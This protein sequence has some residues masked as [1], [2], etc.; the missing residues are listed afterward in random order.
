MISPLL[1]AQTEGVV[2]EEM[3]GVLGW[4]GTVKVA[5]WVQGPPALTVTVYEPGVRLEIVV[6]VPL[7]DQV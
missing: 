4:S 7:F 6:P 1:K 2:V 3:F 5:V